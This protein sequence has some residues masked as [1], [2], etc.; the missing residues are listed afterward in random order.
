MRLTV[1]SAALLALCIAGMP[2]GAAA[3]TQSV[4]AEALQPFVDRG[5]IAGAVVLIAD[6]TAPLEFDAVGYADLNAKRQ[7]PKDAVFWLASTYKPFVGTAVMMMVEEGRIDLDA[8][9]ANYLPGFHPPL[10]PGNA[11]TAR[12]ASRPVTVRMLLSHSGGINP[13]SPPQREGPPPPTLAELAASYAEGP[14]LFEPGT[15]FSYSNASVDTAARVVEV[16][17]GMPFDRFLR[18][19]LF[20][21]LGMTETSFCLPEARRKRLPTAYYLPDGGTELAPAPTTFFEYALHDEC[22]DS[23]AVTTIFSTA[24][25]LARFAQMLLLGGTLDGRRYLTRASIDEMTRNQLSDEVQR[26]V[27]GSGPPDYISYGLGW[28]VSLDGSY[29]HPGVAMTDIRVDP[30]HRVATIL[31]MQSTS[32]AAFTARAELLR[33]SDARYAA[34]AKRVPAE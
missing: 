19:R 11:E 34:K 22:E 6:R 29:F 8:P 24:T 14:L 21:P 17:S 15:R 7:M 13:N 26:T 9:V 3:Q 23:R 30:T 2:V 33:A 10:R 25:D 28:G 4:T 27:P 31:L 16:V 12:P 1:R 18:N 20:E 5:E 32:P